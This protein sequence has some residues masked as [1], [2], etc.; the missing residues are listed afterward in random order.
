MLCEKYREHKTEC[1]TYQD[2]AVC[3]EAEMHKRRAE[4]ARE[5]CQNMADGRD[6]PPNTSVFAADMQRWYF[7]Q[8]LKQ[9][10]IFLCHA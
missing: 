3:K 2:C 1:T 6:L 4:F 7:F 8:S 9:K 5:E 10:N